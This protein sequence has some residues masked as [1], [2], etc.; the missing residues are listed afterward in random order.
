[1]RWCYRLM[2]F[3][4]RARPRVTPLD[5]ATARQVLPDSA[6]H[7]FEEMPPGDQQHALCVLRALRRAG[8]PLEVE[9]AALLHDVGKARGRLTLGRR[10][11]IIL[12]EDLGNNWLYRLASPDPTGWRYPFYVHLHHAEMGASRCEEAGCSRLT[13]ALVRQH[14]GPPGAANDPTLR[15]LLV[16]LK[17]ADN[18]C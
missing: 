5:L 17:K 15:D 2:Q 9:P 4:T 11:L 7:L 1:M 10:T 14:E 6:Y 18:E 3:V 8:A 16:K 12:L 13:V